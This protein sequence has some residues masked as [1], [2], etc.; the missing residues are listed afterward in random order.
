MSATSPMFAQIA[1]EYKK[2][3]MLN[4]IESNWD[5]DSQ[6]DWKLPKWKSNAPIEDSLNLDSKTMR[7][8]VQI[9]FLIFFKIFSSLI[10]WP[11]NTG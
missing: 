8:Q 7:L 5:E 1:E 2:T 11:K 6:R 3:H 10:A 4:M 9:S